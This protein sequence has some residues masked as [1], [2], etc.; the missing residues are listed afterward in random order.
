MS[1]RKFTALFITVG[2]IPFMMLVF[3]F[4]ELGNRATPIILGLPFSFFWVILWIV[5]TFVALIGL[6][7]L[8]PEK[9]AEED[10]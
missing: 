4:F 7:F 10:L 1:S 9:D 8:D 3:P 6:Y 2:L 5:I